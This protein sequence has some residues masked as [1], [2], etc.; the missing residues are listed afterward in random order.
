VVL[1][2]DLWRR[3]FGSNPAVIGTTVRLAEQAYTVI[4]VMGSD[5]EEMSSGEVAVYI[6]LRPG[7]TGRGVG[8]NY[9][10]AGR[11]RPGVPLGQ[12]NAEAAAL[13]ETFKQEFPTREWELG[14]AFTRFHD[15]LSRDAKPALLLMLGAVA[16]LLLIACANTASLLLARASGRGR[17][18]S[19]RAALGATRTRIVRQLLTEA[20]LL[21]VCG[22]MIGLL[23]AYW[24]V[25]ALLSL[26]PASFP[27]YQEV[28]IDA[29][30]LGV[31]LGLAVVT[32]LLFG[33]APAS[34]LSRQ[35]LVEAFKDDATRTT[36]GRRS[37]WA[38]QT[39]VVA[40][41]AMCML[42]LVGAGLLL[43]TFMKLRAVDPGFDI[44]GVVTARMSLQGER[45]ASREAF[46]RLVEEGLQRLRGIPGVQAAA[47]VNGVPI[48]RGLNLNVT[49]PDGPLQGDELV[50]NASVDWR[51]ASST[52]FQTM[53]IPIIRGRAF[54]D[55]DTAGAPRV[56]VVN[57]QFVR[58][59]FKGQNP[60]GHRMTVFDDP[61]MEIVGVA[62]DVR[63][64]GL[65][66]PGVALMYV[67]VVQT[68]GELLGISNSYFPV[69]WVVRSSSGGAQ[70][71]Q[72][73]REEMRALDPSQPISSFRSMEEIKAAEFQ[74]E[75]FQ[76]TLLVL[77]AAIG[78]LLAAA[79]IYGLIAYSVSQRTRELGIRIALGA[80][81]AGILRSIVAQGALLALA[82][83]VIGIAAALAGA[84]MIQ[85]FLF[86]V[87]TKD[88]LT[89]AAVGG[90][91]ILVAI[92]ASFVPALRAVRLNP[93]AALRE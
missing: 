81:P 45:Y 20:V 60:L 35:D 43:Q 4:G 74:A 57:E 65:V 66:G 80:R 12:A 61:P 25:P 93:V 33:L 92:V 63:E 11:L 29:T 42:L 21:S 67:P 59:F 54:D 3:Q 30:V 50:E 15:T 47:L 27:I 53:G 91:L 86:D 90:L 78:L 26:L 34:S 87:S 1:S 5:H 64:A 71:I 73:I 56:A 37:A 51:F 22:A 28:R 13:F 23:L 6:P 2:H 68:S 18:I 75:R 16:T 70:L 52:Y 14:M 46:N 58:R 36:A 38:R 41:V 8:Y 32:G 77:L 85:S 31:T 44:R 49:I 48:E 79:G 7:N 55:R 82:G 89:L 17:E 76:M 72:R 84:R 69:S 62:K 39:L 10:V 9:S 83:V 88:P 40:E 24:S 19:V